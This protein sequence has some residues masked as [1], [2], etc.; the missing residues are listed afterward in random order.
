MTQ[1]CRWQQ[2]GLMN[3]N[4]GWIAVAEVI[5]IRELQAA[6]ERTRRRASDNRSIES[7]LVLMRENLAWAAERLRT[8]PV[9]EHQELLD[10]IEKLA[11]AIRYG[12]QMLGESSVNAAIPSNRNA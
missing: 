9:Q 3:D 7:A 2:D 10:R 11:A 1:F 12:I 5:Q 4:K 6:R 8:S